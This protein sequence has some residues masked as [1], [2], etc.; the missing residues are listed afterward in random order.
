MKHM[1]VFAFFLV[2]LLAGCGSIPVVPVTQSKNMVPQSEIDACSASLRGV[3]SALE[4]YYTHYKSYPA[5]L[6]LLQA[7]G[8]LPLG[9]GTDPWGFTFR[10]EEWSSSYKL[11]SVG[12][13]GKPG[14][15]DDVPPPVNPQI[16]SF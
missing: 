11:G 2:V 5:N 3:Q 7:A 4:L 10:Y 9:G 15:A 8:Y 13:D 16:H 12:R 14:T 6:N 1:I